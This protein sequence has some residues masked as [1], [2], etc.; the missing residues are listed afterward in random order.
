M[1]LFLRNVL[2]C[3]LIFTSQSLVSLE[4][5]GSGSA[6]GMSANTVLNS[7][8]PYKQNHEIQ[9]ISLGKVLSVFLLVIVIAIAAVFLMKHFG[10]NKS[11]A[12]TDNSRKIIIDKTAKITQSL[13]VSIVKIDLI[14]YH[15]FH[16]SHS[17]N[18]K[19]I[20]SQV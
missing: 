2:V 11:I 9:E 17:I 1:K 19:S 18:V 15:V 13:S 8:I 10:I 12:T 16:N 7:N 3:V 5:S 20:K 4:A 14:E 6:E